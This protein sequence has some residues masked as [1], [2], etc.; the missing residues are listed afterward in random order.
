[1][2]KKGHV[3]V[4]MCIGC[5]KRRKKE[6]MVRLVKGSDGIWLFDEKKKLSGRGY[7]L[8]HDRICLKLAQKKQK[9]FESLKPMGFIGYSIEKRIF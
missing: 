6:E 9:G 3:P 8:C 7:Y 5:R 1:M 2:S 4:R